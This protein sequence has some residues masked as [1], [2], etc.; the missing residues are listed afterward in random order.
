MPIETN[1][2][3]QLANAANRY[4]KA[5]KMNLDEFKKGENPQPSKEEIYQRL[6]DLS[7]VVKEI[8]ATQESSGAWITK[9]R[10]F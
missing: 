3:P 10:S 7:E 6:K 9:K 2:E 5:I 1:L 8:I 4:N